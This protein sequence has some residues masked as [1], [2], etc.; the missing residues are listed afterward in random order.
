MTQQLHIALLAAA[1]LLLLCGLFG[2]ARLALRVPVLARPVLGQRGLQRSR[3]LA[4]S[5]FFATLEPIAR[6]V[7]AVLAP[8]LPGRG[9]SALDG[10]IARSGCWL[11]LSAEECVALC[12]LSASAALGVALGVHRAVGGLP[13]AAGVA[14]GTLYP[15]LK[16]HGIAQQR[17][18][19]IGRRLPAAIDLLSLCMGAGMDFVGALEMFVDEHPDDRNALVEELRRVLQELS[20]GRMRRDALIGFAERAPAEAVRDFV[21]ALVQAEQKGTPLADVLALQAQML[22]MRRS[23]AAEEAAARASVLLL[24]PMLLLLGC[25]LL[26]LLGPVLV[27]GVQL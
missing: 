25:V 21:A 26:I 3:G 18:R 9:R 14:L 19:L 17:Q 6:W 15:L 10:L 5:S 11:G 1:Q 13:L 8:L 27:N 2:L 20:I 22:R 24:L 7:G 12:A 4:E 23:V 16:L